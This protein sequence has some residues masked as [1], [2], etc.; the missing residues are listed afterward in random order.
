MEL[1]TGMKK[2]TGTCDSALPPRRGRKLRAAVLGA[3]VLAA[4]MGAAVFATIGATDAR[5]RIDVTAEGEQKLAP[6]TRVIMDRMVEPYQ[7]VIAADFR[8]VEATS[9]LRVQ[10]VLDEMERASPRFRSSMID[11]TSVGGVREYRALVTRLIARDAG[12]LHDQEASIEL[13]GAGAT[14]LAVWLTDTLSPA[15]IAL[16][17]ST[18]GGTQQ[19]DRA[20]AY[21]EQAAAAARIAARDLTTAASKLPESLNQQME[22]QSL[23]DT[24]EA[25]EKL[26]AALR[27]AVTFLDR[28]E[29]ELGRFSSDEAFAGP[30]AD[31]AGPLAAAVGE[32]RAR[33]AVVLDGLSRLQKPDVLRIVDVLRAGSAAIVVGPENGGLAAIDVES[34]LPAAGAPQIAGTRADLRRRTEELLGTAL[35]SLM[36]PDK[37]IVVLTHGEPRRFMGEV[38]IVDR[39]VDRLNFRGIETLEWAAAIEAEPPSVS[40]IDP[41]GK[42]PVVFVVLSPDSSAGEG[43]KG[44]PSGSDRA[45]ALAISVNGQL[46]AG[47]NVLLSLNPSVLPG[48]GERDPLAGLLTRFRLTADT[49][50]PLL[51]EVIAPT[52]RTMDTDRTLL[53]D[54]NEHP[55][56][57]AAKGL[58][59]LFPWPI[60]LSERPEL[61][62]VRTTVTPLYTMEAS[63][64][65]W[66]E[67]QWLK[68]WQTPREQRTMMPDPPTFD[69]GRDSRAPT[70]AG[71][72]PE[73]TSERWVIAAAAERFVVGST[74]QRLVVVGSN[75]WFIDRV[76]RRQVEV[77]GRP[78]PAFPGNYEFLEAAV[79]W[80]AN[81][82]DLIAQSPTAKS[83]PT[84]MALS[85]VTVTRLRIGVIA[86]M[87]LLVLVLG[88]VYRVVRG[89]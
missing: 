56:A 81:Q 73:K 4:A 33:S 16:Q 25:S 5:V 2:E 53:A 45:A 13:A 61:A 44:E 72:K 43:A 6:R 20:R 47:R 3:V 29:K 55:L 79:M 59:T 41:N 19:T 21:F 67:S 1:N 85:P 32:R 83:V 50:R 11:T 86:G 23:P 38:A 46:E 15:L 88:L 14:S 30:A 26:T 54:D 22:G 27:P 18:A 71:G 7:I 12:V 89:K 69:S 78:I 34:L 60:S 80:L 31:A 17:D 52:G 58:N 74:A 24:P 36:T 51:T 65:V 48:Y 42:R 75:S 35:A 66:A 64:A 39:L 37:P 28:L 10:D 82:D 40:A 68:V 63:D 70:A 9:R 57:K 87:P 49:G 77:D 8:S 76:A 84:I 62:E